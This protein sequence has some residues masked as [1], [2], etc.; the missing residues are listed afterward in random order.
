MCGSMQKPLPLPA[1]SFQ[2]HCV[3][4]TIYNFV[5]RLCGNG[6]ET[7]RQSLPCFELSYNE[8]LL[9]FIVSFSSIY[10][11]PSAHVLHFVPSSYSYP[12]LSTVL[13]HI[14]PIPTLLAFLLPPLFP[15]FILLFSHF[16]LL[17][18][19]LFPSPHFQL[20]QIYFPPLISLPLSSPTPTS[21]PFS[22]SFPF[23]FICFFS[24]LTTS[25]ST[26]Y[27]LPPLC[28]LLRALSRFVSKTVLRN[29]CSHLPI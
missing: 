15:L 14:F 5:F 23:Y 22:I 9:A 27:S 3:P 4:S 16:L 26:L 7:E 10:P 19:L 20:L 13:T 6:V 8:Q 2:L 21:S 24:S 28:I 17:F 1:T 29:E 11:S 12:F 18:L 25:S